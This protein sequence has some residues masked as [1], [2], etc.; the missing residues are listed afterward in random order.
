M[1]NEKCHFE[2]TQQLI[3]LGVRIDL[4]TFRFDIPSDRLESVISS[5]QQ[6]L[7]R[8]HCRISARDVARVV[9]K[10]I[11]LGFALGPV[12]RLFTRSCY[13]FINSKPFWDAKAPLSVDVVSELKFWLSAIPTLERQTIRLSSLPAA[14]L[15][16]DASDTGIG[17]VCVANGVHHRAHRPLRTWEIGTSSAFRELKGVL[18][19]VRTFQQFFLN[20]RIKVFSDSTSAV[21]IVRSGS[22]KPP[23]QAIA[24]KIYHTCLDVHGLL[25]IEWLPR[26]KNTEADLL[27][28]EMDLDDWS[29]H[30]AV[31]TMLCS[32]FGVPTVDC[33]ASHYNAKTSK[34][35]SKYWQPG[36]AGVDAFSFSWGGEFCWLVPPIHLVARAL[37]H[38]EECR[39]AGILVVPKWLSAMFWPTLRMLLNSSHCVDVISF[40]PGN[41]VFEHDRPGS[42]FASPFYSHVIAVLINFT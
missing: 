31:F 5:I 35:F 37:T 11:S 17:A 42:V 40:P 24:V 8:S 26:D 3:W 9:G 22:Q 41:F 25:E 13:A 1:L 14:I 38:L 20:S 6:L 33:F 36:T 19:A 23:L 34:F 15:F 21:A 2:P 30:D 7:L 32:R 27:S 28:R 29:V 16:T 39:A 12:T 10:I 18:F 4:S